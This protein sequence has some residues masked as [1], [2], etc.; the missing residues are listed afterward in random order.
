MGIG[1]ILFILDLFW[2]LD[3]PQVLKTREEAI[4]YITMIMFTCSAQHAAVNHGQVQYPTRNIHKLPEEKHCIDRII[5]YC[6][7]NVFI[8]HI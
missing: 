8:F 7:C 3:C 2:S 5:G 4:K 6:P 1:D